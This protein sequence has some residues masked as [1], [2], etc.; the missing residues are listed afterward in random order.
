MPLIWAQLCNWQLVASA[1][2]YYAGMKNLLNI[3]EPR[4]A[5]FTPPTK[6]RVLFNIP[7]YSIDLPVSGRVLLMSVLSIWRSKSQSETR[8]RN[9]RRARGKSMVMSRRKVSSISKMASPA[10]AAQPEPSLCESPVP[11]SMFSPEPDAEDSDYSLDG[12]PL[13]NGESEMDLTS[14]VSAPRDGACV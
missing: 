3:N 5:L 4:E 1:A 7:I 9:R 2:L 12:E 11:A 6:G 14:K 10:A 13:R 8:I